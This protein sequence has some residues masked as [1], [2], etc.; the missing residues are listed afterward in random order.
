MTIYSD[1]LKS[2]MDMPGGR[3]EA[4][5]PSPRSVSKTAAGNIVASTYRRDLFG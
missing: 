2:H 3:L 1:D 4:M 5:M